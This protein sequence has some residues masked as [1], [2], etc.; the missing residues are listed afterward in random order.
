[1][2]ATP[3]HGAKKG[4]K[5]LTPSTG[6]PSH[7]PDKG[8]NPRPYFGALQAKTHNGPL[9]RYPEGAAEPTE[10]R[11]EAGRDQPNSAFPRP[12]TH[13]HGPLTPVWRQ[14]EVVAGIPPVVVANG[15][16]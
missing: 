7:T 6:Y 2:N 11:Q 5:Q 8:N 10:D 3:A 1:M 16:V 15:R 12:L 4:I 14:R 13:G 9:S